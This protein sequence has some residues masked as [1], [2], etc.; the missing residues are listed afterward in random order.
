[1]DSGKKHARAAVILGPGEGRVYSMGRMRAVFKADLDETETKYSV[2][3]W[4]LEPNT[5]GPGVHSHP[6]DHVYYVIEGVLTVFVDG[7]WA[8]A[9]RGSYIRIPGGTPHDFENRGTSP[10]G[11]ISLNAPGGFEAQMPGIVEWFAANPPT[12]AGAT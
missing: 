4:W 6:E 7:A 11:F 8:N 12:D 2:S 3:E 10:A 9:E 5:H 1:M